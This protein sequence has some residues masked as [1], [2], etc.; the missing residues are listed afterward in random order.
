MNCYELI[1]AF[2]DSNMIERSSYI[3]S[4]EKLL[5]LELNDT[6]DVEY[7][8]GYRH[9]VN[10]LTDV[11]LINADLV[12]S[13]A[14]SIAKKLSAIGRY[15]KDLIKHYLDY[16]DDESLSALKALLSDMGADEEFTAHFFD[17][18]RVDNTE[19]AVASFVQ[20][21]SIAENKNDEGKK[22]DYLLGIYSRLVPALNDDT[23]SLSDI[24]SY[25]QQ[26]ISVEL[27]ERTA[28]MLRE[29]CNDKKIPAKQARGLFCEKYEEL[30]LRDL[31]NVSRSN[32]LESVM[33]ADSAVSTPFAD[34]EAES[35]NLIVINLDQRLFDDSPS[36]AA[37][38]DT[39]LSLIYYSYR[40][41]DNHRVLAICIGNI[42]DG[43]GR[44]LKWL[45][46]SYIGIYAEHFIPT[47]EHRKFYH[48][49]QLCLDRCEYLGISA[50]EAA[51]SIIRKYYDGKASREEVSA[52][53]KC[54]I[55]VVDSVLLDFEKV[56]YGY[57]FSDCLSVISGEYRQNEE[58]SFIKNKNQLVLIFNK[59]RHDDR[60]IPCPE[61]AG[62]NISGNS[63]PEVGLR[64]WECKNSICPS[65]SKSNRGKRY[66]KKS[67]FMQRG[68]ERGNENDRISRDLIKNW[69]RD[70]CE[71]S[72]QSEIYEMLIKYFTFDNESVLLINCPECAAQETESLHRT[73]VSVFLSQLQTMRIIP[74]VFR[75]YFD[76]GDY[77][78]R[79]LNQKGSSETA[80]DAL[81]NKNIRESAESVLV[82][83]DSRDILSRVYENTFS[84]AVTSP[85]YYN[86][87][88]YSQW[89]DLY[90]YLLDMYEIINQVYRTMRPG[91]V[92]LYNI[93]DICGNE[94]TVVRSNMG[95]KR[96]LLGAY[97]IHLFVCA[98][99]ELLDD[100]LWDKGEPQSNRQKNDG[101]FTPFYQKPMN[102]YE[103]MFL[104]KKP[105]A[106][107]I[108]C[109]DPTELP[110]VWDSNIVPFAPV[111]K[112]NSKGENTLGHT[113]P[114]PL[115]IPEFAAKA[116]TSGPSDI[117]LEPFA[118]S[119]TSLIAADING[120][121]A[122]GAELSDEY[123]ELIQKIC[124]DN[125]VQL[126][127]IDTNK[128]EG[129]Q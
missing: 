34:M 48:P 79:Y 11:Y 123:F 19:K 40:L 127:V 67:N 8:E 89:P 13:C 124:A 84:S 108:R 54:D 96:I 91:G 93:G 36:E 37:F 103:H 24:F 31:Q 49:E 43:S 62:L 113:A 7:S 21:W 59:Y 72:Q 26:F 1:G 5:L 35:Q 63:F 66:S 126:N 117:M 58:I 22:Y 18:L 30:L 57:T 85:P 109:S 68:F 14:N 98:G 118:G 116:F 112:I 45:A 28:L 27:D 12:K 70:I 74:D 60:K 125:N 46:Y 102:V 106:P 77:V 99:F 111:I 2:L 38:W 10:I 129:T 73:A 105:G 53:L 122:F 32:L 39:V 87:R 107:I 47:K 33:N 64:S 78:K 121:K 88:L 17:D 115:D 15:E 44:N 128:T 120:V 56:W 25:N 90:L 41:L 6:C 80:P 76:H 20:N 101:K 4:L 75:S 119:G 104:F 55:L 83:G 114:F 71:V 65:R 110:E 3:S 69:R 9:I 82:H 61:C 42:F 51:R 94:N 100:L 16:G 50:D 29:Y 95:N 92:Y 86:A 23:L 81:F 97:T 52:A